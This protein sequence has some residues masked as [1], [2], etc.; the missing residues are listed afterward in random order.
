MSTS[1]IPPAKDT[2]NC[3]EWAAKI[4]AWTW[5]NGKALTTFTCPVHGTVTFDNRDIPPSI[6]NQA[7]EEDE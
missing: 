4:Q 7:D 3:E 5:K 2:C 1:V 6:I